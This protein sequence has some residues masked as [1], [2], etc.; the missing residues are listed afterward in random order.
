MSA[1]Q[2][3]RQVSFR[4][5]DEEWNLLKQIIYEKSI[6]AGELI[7]KTDYIKGCLFKTQPQHHN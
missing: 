4:L 3:K 2:E 1:S 6:Q 5:S 7:S